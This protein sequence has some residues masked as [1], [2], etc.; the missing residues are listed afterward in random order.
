MGEMKRAIAREIDERKQE[1][2]ASTLV[3]ATAIIVAIRLARV[4]NLDPREYHV[5][6]AIKG[7]TF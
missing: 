7:V 5:Q 2:F 3:V 4:S 6:A 1:R